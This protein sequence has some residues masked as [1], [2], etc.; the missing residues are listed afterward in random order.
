MKT[1]KK[2]MKKMSKKGT[3]KRKKHY[4]INLTGQAKVILAMAAVL[5][6]VVVFVNIRSYFYS[7]D[8]L[9]EQV[10]IPEN[11][12]S[13]GE[14]LV[15]DEKGRLHY[16]DD[17][18]VSRC[19]IDV[20]AYQKEIN[21]EKVKDDGVDFA[22]IRL[23]YR[24]Y[25]EGVI[26]MDARYEQNIQG[27]RDA[28][29]EVGVYFFSQ[30]VSVEEAIDEAK[31]VLK[32]IHGKHVTCPVAFDMEPI[33]GAERIG[34][35]TIEEKT[36]IAD[37]FCEI[38]EKNG[39]T[40]VVYGNPDWLMGDLD[41]SYLGKRE[42]WLAHY[43]EITDYPYAHVMWQYTDGGHVEG[44]EGGVDMNILMTPKKYLVE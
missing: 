37:A 23:G 6:L 31:Y 27:A 32:E 36:A 44:I 13:Y 25:K 28:G 17:T 1:T 41:L 39:Y 19:G 24:G 12:F 15:R 40:P 10:M 29:L 26:K 9:G 4:V 20:S 11:E 8:G 42:V 14:K 33:A 2:P 21:W 18:Y 35:L 30:A 5:I 3:K 43:T 16:E 34:G 7:Y 38:I 22:M